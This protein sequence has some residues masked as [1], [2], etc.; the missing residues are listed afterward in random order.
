MLIFAPSFVVEKINMLPSSSGQDTH[1]SSGRH[2]F[3][4]GWQ[5]A[6]VTGCA[7]EAQVP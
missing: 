4:S 6:R 5:Y 3:E 2:R 7:Y 1:L